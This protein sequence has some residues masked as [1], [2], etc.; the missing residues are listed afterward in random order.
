MTK[1]Y[2][3][4]VTA[5]LCLSLTLCGCG[6][7]SVSENPTGVLRVL[8]P[9]NA[10]E[11]SLSAEDSALIADIFANQLMLSDSPACGF[12]AIEIDLDGQLFYPA[13]DGCGIVYNKNADLY[14]TL[15]EDHLEALHR[16][17]ERNS[18]TFPYF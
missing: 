6:I 2:L 10:F 17:L 4:L 18:V 13:Q 12:S 7:V 16:I 5:V 1:R 9:D 15:S 14:I 3:S 11:T 8:D